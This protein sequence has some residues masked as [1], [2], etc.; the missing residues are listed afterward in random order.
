LDATSPECPNCG[1]TPIELSIYGNSSTISPRSS[2]CAVIL[3]FPPPLVQAE[4]QKL[5]AAR[6]RKQRQVM[7]KIDFTVMV[8]YLLV[9]ETTFL[10]N[11][12]KLIRVV[13]NVDTRAA[14][15]GLRL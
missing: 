1:N 9:N 14:H 3:K 12:Q 6:V 10:L 5:N 13:H 2:V 4:N 15:Y 7:R 11:R 8:N